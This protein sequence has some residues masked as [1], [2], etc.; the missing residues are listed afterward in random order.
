MQMLSAL[1]EAGFSPTKIPALWEMLVAARQ[2]ES[3]AKF[4]AGTGTRKAVLLESL[5]IG[6]PG[7]AQTKL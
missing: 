4:E 7:C 6:L 3:E 5:L 2:H 1:A